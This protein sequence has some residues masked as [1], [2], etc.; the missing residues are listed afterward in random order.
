MGPFQDASQY[1]HEWL[2]IHPSVKEESLTDWLLYHLSSSNPRVHCQAFTRRE[3]ALIGAD[4]EWWLL[5]DASLGMS[6]KPIGYR[7]LIQA[8]K[9]IHDRDNYALLAYSNRYGL[10][11]DRLIEEA[12]LRR[13]MPFYAYYTNALPD[14]SRQLARIPFIDHS[15]LRP[16]IPHINGCFLSSAFEVHKHLF[17]GPRKALWEKTL[18]DDSF[19]LSLLDELWD[20][21][22]VRDRMKPLN[23]YFKKCVNDPSH[24]MG[25]LHHGSA[26]PSYVQYLIDRQFDHSAFSCLESQFSHELQGVGGI[27]LIDLRGKQK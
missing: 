4:W 8:K 1:C 14:L 27:G 19:G 10:Q 25:F 23:D 6:E 26:L 22:S 24:P 18:L 12:K 17:G 20:S 7:F 15:L 13:A 2:S 16:G 11:I 5:T 21:T 3:E 9:L